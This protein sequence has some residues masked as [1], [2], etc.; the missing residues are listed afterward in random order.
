[1]RPG[2][3]FDWI[4]QSGISKEI[5]QIPVMPLMLTGISSDKGPED[6]RVVSGEDFYKLYG[7]DIS[8]ER[9]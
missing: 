9:H 3:I 5:T 8:Y 1:M 2:T 6:L 4:D 7:Y